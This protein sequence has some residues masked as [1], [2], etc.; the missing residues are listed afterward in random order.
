MVGV[1]R[2][3]LR[4]QLCNGFFSH[5]LS[6][7]C[8]LPQPRPPTPRYAACDPTKNYSTALASFLFFSLLGATPYSVLTV[9][10]E[11]VQLPTLCQP[12]PASPVDRDLGSARLTAFG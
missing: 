5:F 7:A 9:G 1:N 6:T 2:V 10:R 8:L 12:P 3:L 11:R 4:P